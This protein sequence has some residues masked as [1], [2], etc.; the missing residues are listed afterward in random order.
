MNNKIFMVSWNEEEAKEFKERLTE[1]GWDVYYESTD[2]KEANKR[3]ME[4]FP[5]YVIISLDKESEK[6]IK[7]AEAITP[8]AK[9]ND[10]TLLLV[11][12]DKSIVEEADGMIKKARFVEPSMLE[13]VLGS[14]E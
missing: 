12:G 1:K 13:S 9:Q 10:F 14:P 4:L 11:G 6:G 2:F 7:M 8:Q 3:I 5:A